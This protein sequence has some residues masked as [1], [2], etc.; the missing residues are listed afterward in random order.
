MGAVPQGRK[1]P[2]SPERKR[3]ETA[4]LRYEFLKSQLDV[5]LTL[6][7]FLG[8]TRPGSELGTSCRKT[9]LL[10][11]AAAMRAISTMDLS[12]DDGQALRAKLARVSQLLDE[13]EPA[14]DPRTAPL[15]HLNGHKGPGNGQ[16]NGHVNGSPSNGRVLNGD[17]ETQKQEPLTPRELEVLKCIA[18]GYSTKELA[19]MLGIT[20]KTASCHRSHIMDKLGL[21]N[22]AD[23]VRYA[24]RE[25]IVLP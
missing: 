18:E 1:V 6:A 17:G 19:G 22:L 8:R 21:H 2:Q 10:G 23:L 7:V 20:F 4:R 11:Y 13:T 12:H 16:V 15:G 14:D 3:Y 9:A 25:R 5:S 24:I